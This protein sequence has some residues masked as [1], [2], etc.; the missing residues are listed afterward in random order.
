M[1]TRDNVKT[2]DFSYLNEKFG[3]LMTKTLDPNFVM[4]FPVLFSPSEIKPSNDPFS[5]CIEIQ[6]DENQGQKALKA[7]SSD[8]YGATFDFSINSIV[9]DLRIFENDIQVSIQGG[10]ILRSIQSR[11][12]EYRKYLND[13]IMRFDET[14]YKQKFLKKEFFVKVYES[15]YLNIGVVF[16]TQNMYTF[17]LEYQMSISHFLVPMFA[18]PSFTLKS[19]YPPTCSL[20]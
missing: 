2:V 12:E 11:L 15:N 8:Y 10:K 19:P 14:E 5:F 17:K 3:G 9:H 4:D 7:V 18:L 1:E 6:I 16:H 20:S 13:N